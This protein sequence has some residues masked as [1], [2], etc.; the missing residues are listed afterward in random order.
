[1]WL[2]KRSSRK[3]K[4][5]KYNIVITELYKEEVSR[6]K[7]IEESTITEIVKVP[8]LSEEPNVVSFCWLNVTSVTNLNKPSICLLV[9]TSTHPIKM[10]ILLPLYSP[11]S[12]V[13]S[14]LFLNNT[15]IT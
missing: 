1:M 10:I 2:K 13:Q 11:I 14:R 3:V 5:V 8:M 6:A 9:S 4:L 7:V 15:K 12:V